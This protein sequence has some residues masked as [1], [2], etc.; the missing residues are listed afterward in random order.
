MLASAKYCLEFASRSQVVEAQRERLSA[1]LKYAYDKVP[2]Y[3]KNFDSLGIAPDDFGEVP[4]ISK[5]PFT[6]KADFY[7]NYPFGLFAVPRENI[8][9]IHAS[10]GSRGSPILVG[11]T[12]SDLELWADIMCR[13]LRAAGVRPGMIAHIAYGYGLFTGGLGCHYGAEKLGCS[14]IPISAGATK[15]QVKLIA[16]LQP[17]V[18]MAT[19]SYMLTILDEAINQGLDPKKLSLKFGLFGA[20]PWTREMRNEIE[21]RSTLSATDIYGLS[22]LIGP[23]VAQECVETKDGLHIWE[24]HFY[25]EIINPDTEEVLADGLVGELVLTSLTKEA[26]P[27]VRYRTGDITSLLPGTARPGMRRMTRIIGRSDDMIVLRGVNLFPSQIEAI[28]VDTKGCSPHYKI[29]IVRRDRLDDLV[30]HV[31]LSPAASKLATEDGVGKNIKDA[32]GLTV[33]VVAHPPGTL[34]RF[35]GKAQR[36]FDL[37]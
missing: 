19:P 17:D 3:R 26:C 4:D 29:D 12:K 28:I 22:E 16:E 36:V 24:D 37:R 18:I 30:V 20:E 13:S 33:R 8:A 7:E 31:E 25:P 23:G 2:F 5:F 11:Y 1:T 34:P 9:R 10:S 14:V 32:L 27:I 15:R 21:E 35:E 6:R